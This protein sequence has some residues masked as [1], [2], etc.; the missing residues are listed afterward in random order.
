MSGF[1]S[2]C[3]RERESVRKRRKERRY[4]AKP[5]FT[6]PALAHS[7]NTLLLQTVIPS[8]S[9]YFSLD[10]A[11]VCVVGLRCMSSNIASV[12]SQRVCVSVCVCVT[13]QLREGGKSLWKIQIPGVIQRANPQRCQLTDGH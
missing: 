11:W 3:F 2:V 9:A 6:H 13:Q 12:P 7:I 1:V 5:L 4:S 8:L 10:C